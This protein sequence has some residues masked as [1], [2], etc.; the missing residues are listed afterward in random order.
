MFELL[1]Y[2]IEFLYQW[3]STKWIFSQVIRFQ[4]GR[5]QGLFGF[6]SSFYLWV[7][8]YDPLRNDKLRLKNDYPISDLDKVD[9]YFKNCIKS[10]SCTCENGQKIRLKIFERWNMFPKLD[11]DNFFF[12][13][14]TFLRPKT[15][16]LDSL[17]CRLYTELSSKK[18]VYLPP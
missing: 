2:F 17:Q 10:W 7:I 13:C 9:F 6:Y 16:F 3:L 1:Q 12:L 8:G 4:P 5:I 18:V 11:L 15:S 14:I